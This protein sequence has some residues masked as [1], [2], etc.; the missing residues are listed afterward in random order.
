MN[1]VQIKLVLTLS[2]VVVVFLRGCAKITKKGNV[3]GAD[4]RVIQEPGL[5]VNESLLSSTNEIIR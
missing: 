4:Y 2:A 3:P 5:T 1:A